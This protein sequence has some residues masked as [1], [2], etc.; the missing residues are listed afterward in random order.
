MRTRTKRKGRRKAQ[1]AS[2]GERVKTRRQ[3]D[4]DLM[5]AC[6][7]E[8]S[9][10]A[11]R[12]FGD[13]T[14]AEPAAGESLISASKRLVR[15]LQQHVGGRKAASTLVGGASAVLQDHDPRR[16]RRSKARM[17]SRAS[18]GGDASS[19][20]S[21]PGSVANAIRSIALR[22]V[23]KLSLSRAATL[24]LVEC[25]RSGGLVQEN[26]AD[27]FVSDAFHS[28]S[29]QRQDGPVRLSASSTAAGVLSRGL[30]RLLHVMSPSY[31]FY[32]DEPTVGVP[33]AVPRCVTAGAVLCAEDLRAARLQ[34]T[35]RGSSRMSLCN[36]DARVAPGR[37]E[38]AT[39]AQIPA[40]SGRGG[41]NCASEHDRGAERRFFPRWGAPSTHV[42]RGQSLASQ[43]LPEIPALSCILDTPAAPAPPD[44]TATEA[45]R[46]I[47]VAASLQCSCATVFYDRGVTDSL[48][49]WCA[50]TSSSAVRS[51]A[52]LVA[53][54]GACGGGGG[55]G[56]DGRRPD[57]RT[58][59][60]AG[61][62]IATTFGPWSHM[63]WTR[64][65]VASVFTAQPRTGSPL[66]P[67]LTLMHVCRMSAVRATTAGAADAP[68]FVWN[69]RALEF[70]AG[71]EALACVNNFQRS[72][73]TH[74]L[75][76]AEESMKRRGARSEA[77]A[78]QVRE[79][80]RALK[81]AVQKCQPFLARKGVTYEMALALGCWMGGVEVSNVLTA[82]I[83]IACG[84]RYVVNCALNTLLALRGGAWYGRAV[85]LVCDLG[86]A[87]VPA[88][89]DAS[90]C[91]AHSAIPGSLSA[92]LLAKQV[93]A[94]LSINHAAVARLVSH[95]VC[96]YRG[97]HNEAVAQACSEF[98]FPVQNIVAAIGINGLSS[99][100]AAAYDE[101]APAAAA[102]P[103]GAGARSSGTAGPAARVDSSRVRAPRA[104]LRARARDADGERERAPR[105]GS[106]A[107]V[108]QAGEATQRG[109]P[110][111]DLRGGQRA[112]TK[113]AECPGA[114]D[115]SRLVRALSMQRD[116]RSLLDWARGRGRAAGIFDADALRSS[117]LGMA[118]LYESER[119]Q[120]WCGALLGRTDE[121]SATLMRLAH[122]RDG[123]DEAGGE[124][125]ADAVVDICEA[126]ESEACAKGN[127]DLLR[128]V[129]GARDA[130]HDLDR[131]RSLS[132]SVQRTLRRASAAHAASVAKRLDNGAQS[133]TAALAAASAAAGAGSCRGAGS[134]RARA[135][136]RA[137][138]NYLQLA[139][140]TAASC[141]GKELRMRLCTCAAA[142]SGA[143]RGAVGGTPAPQGTL[144]GRTDATDGGGG[145][146]GR[147]STVTVTVEAAHAHHAQPS[148]G[149]ARCPAAPA[150]VDDRC[151]SEQ[152]GRLET[153]ASGD[154]ASRGRD[155]AAA[156]AMTTRLPGGSSAPLTTS[157]VLQESAT[158]CAATYRASAGAAG[159]GDVGGGDDRG[160]AACAAWVA[161]DGDDAAMH[162]AERAAQSVA[163]EVD[164]RG[165]AT[166]QPAPPSRER[167]H[168]GREVLHMPIASFK[169]EVD[170]GVWAEK[171]VD[172][173]APFVPTTR[174]A[175]DSSAAMPPQ[176]YMQH[177]THPCFAAA[178]A[179]GKER[180]SATAHDARAF[181]LRLWHA[182]NAYGWYR[183]DRGV[184]RPP[185]VV[186]SRA[187]QQLHLHGRQQ[188]AVARHAHHPRHVAHCNASVLRQD[189][190]P[191]AA[192]SASPPTHDVASPAGR[193]RQGRT[194]CGSCA[195]PLLMLQNEW[196]QTA[197]PWIGNVSTW[198]L[199]PH[200]R[201]V[202]DVDCQA[203]AC[204]D[205]P[206]DGG[207]EFDGIDHMIH[208]ERA[209]G[210]TDVAAQRTAS[211][212]FC[213]MPGRGP[214]SSSPAGEVP[215][216]ETLA[217]DE[218]LLVQSVALGAVPPGILTEVN[219]RRPAGHQGLNPFLRRRRLRV[220]EKLSQVQERHGV[221]A[222]SPAPQNSSPAPK[223]LS[224]WAQLCSWPRVVPAVRQC[225]TA[226][227][228][229]TRVW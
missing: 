52:P 178:A 33:A 107:V 163:D 18:S 208:A 59:P 186:A 159:A 194:S 190:M 131:A 189:R 125:T 26:E 83:S 150:S 130:L 104:E 54:A 88:L 196:V 22:D 98:L 32:G 184:V 187:Q 85:R 212:R 199:M 200:E 63:A 108:Q 221:S 155:D 154:G 64:K 69:V 25:F 35:H 142:R 210:A 99:S 158:S 140:R 216:Q 93:I 118:I 182:Q 31:V 202:A 57:E 209:A 162:H 60:A 86:A 226:V 74:A 166:P 173:I 66:V 149:D 211:G 135:L 50:H 53:S 224:V 197:T 51:G 181:H 109:V 84:A 119:V 92:Q 207:L 123:D 218:P 43:S 13:V 47:L 203:R 228:R 81:E 5:S 188:H 174:H 170:A 2:C 115:A 195:A 4:G 105:R 90:R 137:T 126:S 79:R 147:R 144:R 113:M 133:A 68:V 67:E 127:F 87:A 65:D 220:L 206:E 180:G 20:P 164:V 28:L 198:R 95:L 39:C 61:I 36:K 40:G 58:G 11:S 34:L 110:E 172:A 106:R 12:R 6:A 71:M 217:E 122:I 167:E 134:S 204:L 72:M 3:V 139:L 165:T 223:D 168:H 124:G 45:I 179:S 21:P 148:H 111:P 201:R 128:R 15:E 145:A 30:R 171:D 23:V 1:Q 77:G 70:V 176:Q 7:A 14:V 153:D 97:G 78:A 10:T 91:D 96:G 121:T 44:T 177:G 138:V 82:L 141:A 17:R 75:S 55:G 136:R 151:E 49:L 192:V 112:R 146:T 94:P 215:E 213:A 89:R 41:S 160:V 24:W 185:R 205:R 193:E 219:R 101:T 42:A 16:E 62:T 9:N 129:C 46:S 229:G 29:P 156:V 120:Q 19:R 37:S 80:A 191:P 227:S 225:V 114:H 214:Q 38:C 100:A 143:R 8:L 56:E 222:A 117:A 76:L 152:G 48:Q 169:G 157:P 27:A 73:Q 161:G 102:C 183:V 175:P 116:E 103:D 132:A